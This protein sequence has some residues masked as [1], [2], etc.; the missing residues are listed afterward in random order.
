[1]Q[2]SNGTSGQNGH[3]GIEA[4]AKLLGDSVHVPH[5]RGALIPFRTIN[6]LPQPRKTFESLP[7][8]A[9]D[10]AEKGQLNPLIVARFNKRACSQYLAVIN[11]LWGTT[12]RLSDVHATRWRG[13][14]VYYVL[15]AGERRYRSMKL[16]QEAG[17]E[18]V[19]RMV[20]GDAPAPAH[21]ARRKREKVEVRLCDNISPLPALFLQ[22][23]ENTHMQVPP[24]EEAQAY[25]LLFRL[26][27]QADRAF[28]IA[29]FARRVG[30]SP[31]TVRHALRFS[32]LPV[33]IRGYVESG[34]LPYGIGV[35]LTRL[36]QLKLGMKDLDWWAMRAIVERKKVP[37]FH[38]LVTRYLIEKN[39]DQMDLLGIVG[40]EEEKFQRRL[41]IRKT[42]QANIIQALWAWIDYFKKV[43]QLFEEG[44]LGKD[45]SPFSVKSPVRV[46][47]ALID[48]MERTL[49]HLKRV[50]THATQL[51]AMQMLMTA[52]QVAGQLD[53]YLEERSQVPH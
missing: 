39:S 28:S 42:V 33:L 23:S 47:L 45:D 15:L 4:L 5:Y 11:R 40:R 21:S 2:R 22:L 10:I 35:E 41:H 19:H 44:K 9:L 18:K 8:L 34:M 49:P 7:T 30:R 46:F 37:E 29:Q 26:V 38:D 25:S 43:L 51:R 32:E 3:N 20:F 1:M 50:T 13:K 14:R 12:F 27:R 16:L 31:E 48:V 24:Y 6:V 17:Y 53:S 52:R 36:H